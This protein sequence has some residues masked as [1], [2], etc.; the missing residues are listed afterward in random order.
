MLNKITY[1]SLVALGA[2]CMLLSYATSM[3]GFAGVT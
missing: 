2:M 1:N 3:V